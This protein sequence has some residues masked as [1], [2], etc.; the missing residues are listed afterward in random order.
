MELKGKRALVTGGTRGIGK[1]IALTLAE[2]GANVA[3]NYLRQREPAAETLEEIESHGVKGLLYTG[4]GNAVALST[5]REN[6][7]YSKPHQV[8]MASR[9]SRAVCNLLAGKSQ[10]G[11]PMAMEIITRLD[12]GMPANVLRTS[13]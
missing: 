3:V 10:S 11:Y 1:A 12:S 7:V 6:S 13:G 9:G 5:E 8:A 2:A 4:A